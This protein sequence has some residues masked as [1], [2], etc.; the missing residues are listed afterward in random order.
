MV[1]LQRTDSLTRCAVCVGRAQIAD[2]WS[3]G[4]MVYVMLVGAYPFERPEDKHDNQKLQKMIQARLHAALC[5]PS[6]KS[7]FYWALSD[8]IACEVHCS[9]LA[10]PPRRTSREAWER[11]CAA[12]RQGCAV[13]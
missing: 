12:V 2:I 13:R 1:A 3:C 9:A 6:S 5:N 8:R 10:S 4:V 11:V 7:L